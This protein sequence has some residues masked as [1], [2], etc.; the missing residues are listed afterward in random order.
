MFLL[1]KAKEAKIVKG[2]IACNVS[3]V[4]MFSNNSTLHKLQLEV[5]Q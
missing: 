4:A 2:V 3:P 1:I 5:T